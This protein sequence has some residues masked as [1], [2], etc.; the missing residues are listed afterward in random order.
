MILSNVHRVGSNEAGNIS[1]SHGLIT[2]T[3]VHAAHH[4][5]LVFDNAIVFP[6]LINS[7]DHL[8][9]NLFPQ[10]GHHIYHNYT[11]WGNYIHRYYKP[12]IDAILN[13]PLALRTAWGVYKNMLCGVTTVVNH[14][15]ELELKDVPINV[16]QNCQSLHSVRFEKHWKRRLN[17]PLK[18]TARVAIH[19]GEGTDEAACDEIEQLIH[20]NLLHRELIGIH[21]VAMTPKQARSFKALV[22]CPQSNY[23]LLGT[24]APVHRLKD[25]VP[26]IFGTDS[27]LTGDW[28]IWEHIRQARKT[29]YL[30]DKELLA[31][32]TTNPAK[33]WG[34]NSGVIAPGNDADLV[35]A[36]L[37]NGQSTMNSLFDVDPADI[38]LVMSKGNIRL[39]DEML[40]SQL[41][42]IDKSRYSKIMINK[43][44]KYVY[45]DLPGL[46]KQIQAYHHHI[47]FPVTAS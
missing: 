11:E 30:S 8:D 45:G 38:L 1:I 14:G 47:Q 26:I 15:N 40:Y 39:F 24:T 6:G 29:T 19:T 12:E 31:N 17:N 22:W 16:M 3:A 44:Y 32:L 34:I 18:L 2:D 37:K 4:P 13:I 46:M 41:D 36:R 21:G 42:S 25:Y 5:K 35:V 43:V 33:V 20:W 7:H 23:F 9:F 28:N 27:T 10:L